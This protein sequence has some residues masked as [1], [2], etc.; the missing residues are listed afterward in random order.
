MENFD[1][2]Y[3]LNTEHFWTLKHSIE[4]VSYRGICSPPL[5]LGLEIEYIN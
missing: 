4:M 5:S 3:V 2:K 1:L